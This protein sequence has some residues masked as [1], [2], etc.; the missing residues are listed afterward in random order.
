M[1]ALGFIEIKHE[2]ESL[3]RMEEVRRKRA[4]L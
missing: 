1:I 4:G 2:G 3:A